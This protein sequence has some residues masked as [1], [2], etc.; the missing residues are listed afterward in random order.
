MPVD[1][2]KIRKRAKEYKEEREKFQAI[3]INEDNT[4]AQFNLG[5]KLSDWKGTWISKMVKDHDGRKVL[6]KICTYDSM[7]DEMKE[8]VQLLLDQVYF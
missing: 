4:D 3:I 7:T 8:L 2:K 1:L 6:R 5:G